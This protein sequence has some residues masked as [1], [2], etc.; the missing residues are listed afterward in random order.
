MKIIDSGFDMDAILSE[1][2]QLTQCDDYLVQN[3]D[4]AVKQD[5]V[6]LF[7]M[8]RHENCHS[9]T[10]LNTVYAHVLK[11]NAS[12]MANLAQY[13][14]SFE[15]QPTENTDCELQDATKFMQVMDTQTVI[16]EQIQRH[17]IN[18]YG[19]ANQIKAYKDE[20]FAD[21]AASS[22]KKYE[23]FLSFLL[24]T[25]GDTFECTQL[26]KEHVKIIKIAL[27]DKKNHTFTTNALS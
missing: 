3:H 2:R 11:L 8:L 5:I 16:N 22:V 17:A 4:N 1:S 27:R 24:I 9:E 6:K 10:V 21:L 14:Q 26:T 13:N 18:R 7:S 20:H 19:L 12:L 23:N 25:L 15:Q